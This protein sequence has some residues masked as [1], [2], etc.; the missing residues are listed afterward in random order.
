MREL[1][2]HGDVAA[3]IPPKGLE[4]LRVLSRSASGKKRADDGALSWGA[5]FPHDRETCIVAIVEDGAWLLT[6][7]N[8]PG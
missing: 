4:D 6:E 3:H 8:L 2:G 5:P 7:T 1:R